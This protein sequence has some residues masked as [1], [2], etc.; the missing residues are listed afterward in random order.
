MLTKLLVAFDAENFD[1]LPSKIEDDG[2]NFGGDF[3]EEIRRDLEA[4]ASALP[5]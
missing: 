1:E 5:A 3:A 4:M 2:P